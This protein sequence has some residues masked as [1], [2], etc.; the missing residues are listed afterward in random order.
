M[1]TLLVKQKS[2]DKF[3]S[4]KRHPIIKRRNTYESP[5]TYYPYDL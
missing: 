4:N 2:V 5:D 3:L 1:S